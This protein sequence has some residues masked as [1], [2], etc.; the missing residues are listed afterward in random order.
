MRHGSRWDGETVDGTMIEYRSS[1]TGPAAAPP[2]PSSRR[3]SLSRVA[4]CDRA[5]GGE[6]VSER[7]GDPTGRLGSLSPRHP[8]LEV[9]PSGPVVGLTCLQPSRERLRGISRAAANYQ[10]DHGRLVR[11]AR[12]ARSWPAGSTT[13]G[14]RPHTK[15]FGVG[16]RRPRRSERTAGG[17]SASPDRNRPRGETP[18]GIVVL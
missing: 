16:A 11:R 10:L 2:Q 1:A 18:P 6:E 3:R 9:V 15:F 5:A 8:A 14:A 13:P 17:M 4:R 7:A 12:P